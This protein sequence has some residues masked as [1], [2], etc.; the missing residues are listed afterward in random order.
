M[1][2]IVE[3]LPIATGSDSIEGLQAHT[4]VLQPSGALDQASSATFQAALSSALMVADSV[5]VDL[6]WVNFID[7]QGIAAM[8]MAIEQAASLG[9]TV[10]FQ[11]MDCPTRAALEAEWNHQRE[12][13]LGP[14]HNCFEAELELFLETRSL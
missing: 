12:L 1:S 5:I 14:W 2:T 7:S 8:V 11:S 4:L 10:S 13:R 3:S 9:K 6:L